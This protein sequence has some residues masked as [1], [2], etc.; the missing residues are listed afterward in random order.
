ML[1]G[2]SSRRGGRSASSC[3]TSGTREPS[4]RSRMLSLSAIPAASSFA[5]L[6]RSP[7]ESRLKLVESDFCESDR[8]FWADN[9]ATLV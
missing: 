8:F 7:L 6:I 3:E 4:W 5:E 2:T 9:E 1:A